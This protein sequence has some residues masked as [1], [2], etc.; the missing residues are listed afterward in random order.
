MTFVTL[1]ARQPAYARI[2]DASR[3]R[4]T[5]PGERPHRALA[6][7]AWIVAG[8]PGSGKTTVARVLAARLSPPAAVLD[9]D[10]V[11]GGFAD[12]VIAA[13][14]QPRGRREGPW[15][16]AHVK[17]HEYAGLAASAKDVRASGC[18]VIVV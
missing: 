13:A 9:K 11:Y 5:P 12:A 16:D 17:I 15:Y 2:V 3:A 1:G 7:G 4:S 6:G 18:P 8:P 10:V 14:N